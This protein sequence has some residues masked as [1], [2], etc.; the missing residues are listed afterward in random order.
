M[1]IINNNN[2][3]SEVIQKDPTII[4]VINRFG[5]ILGTKD[6]TI[7]AICNKHNIDVE[8]FLTIINTFLNKDYFPETTLKKFQI[9][10]I[11]SYLCKTN[12][13][14]LHFQI[15]NIERHFKSLIERSGD[16]NN[17]N[18]IKHFFDEL[19]K[20]LIE[21]INF[22]NNQLFVAAINAQKI[23]TTEKITNSQN[24]EDRINDLKNML[25]MHL[26]GNYDTNLCYA[27]IIA[28][29]TFEKDMQK[30]N[31][32]RDRILLPSYSSNTQTPITQ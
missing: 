1:A 28:I 12:N 32:V 14:Y 8:F 7:S 13:Y 16:E 25:I 11:V 30:N 19:K 24:I 17:L 22:D 26:E 20:D 27:V 15:P 29:H 6:N 9:N 4:P 21:R 5:I 23:D 31:R 18:H 2:L 10:E 3:L